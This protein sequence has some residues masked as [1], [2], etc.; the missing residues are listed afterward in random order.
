MK[1]LLSTILAFSFS[2]SSVAQQTPAPPQSRSIIILGGTA[3]L[4]TGDAI[5]DAAIG[6][7]NGKIDFVG[8]TFQADKSK[9]DD[10]IDATG[11]QIYPGFIVTN[12]TLGLQE[13]GAV[14]A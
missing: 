6:F 13:I 10:I 1:F 5:E 2:F 3:H 11:K 9:Y 4:G 8:R 14:R 7:R 12:T